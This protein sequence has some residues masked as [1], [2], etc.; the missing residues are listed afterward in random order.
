MKSKAITS[1]LFGILSVQNLLASTAQAVP[2]TIQP[3][4]VKKASINTQNL[5]VAERI[6]Q[7]R[8]VGFDPKQAV[9]TLSYLHGSGVQRFE[10]DGSVLVSAT[11]IQDLME[12][13]AV[14]GIEVRILK[15]QDQIVK[16]KFAAHDLNK[17]DRSRIGEAKELAN[18]FD[19][20]CDMD[21]KSL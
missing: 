11:M 7:K 13:A 3:D 14:D 18:A 20:K 1:T 9:E 21:G 15:L 19:L 2:V 5:E 10:T 17:F 12:T 4:G 8:L 6:I 16:V